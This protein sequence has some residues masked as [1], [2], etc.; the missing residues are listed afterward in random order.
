MLR[1][2]TAASVT[3]LA[4]M[5][6]GAAFA[7]TPPGASPGAGATKM[8]Q[9]ECQ[10]LWNRLDSAKSGS[11]TEAQ[12]Q[13]YVTD[14]KAVDA[15]SDGKLSQAEFNAGCNKGQVHGTATTGPGSGTNGA[16]APKK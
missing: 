10:S 16:T 11:V 4:L 7:Q 6:G 1:M 13:A 9:A 8:T 3:A 15:N 12:A 5:L 14:F 2:F